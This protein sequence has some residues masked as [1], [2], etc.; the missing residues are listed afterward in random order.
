MNILE[1]PIELQEK[2]ITNIN[3]DTKLN[4]VCSLW[5]DICKKKIVKV[6][7]E[8]CVCLISPGYAMICKSINHPCI[9]M[10]DKDSAHCAWRCRADTHPCTC[11][12][13]CA[14]HPTTCRADTHLCICDMSDIH[15]SRCKSS[16]HSI[17]L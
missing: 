11:R 10:E 8:P 15:R 2:I 3:N 1:L 17:N 5:N 6:L 16:F 7:R 14:N 9:C 12:N 13:G 4:L